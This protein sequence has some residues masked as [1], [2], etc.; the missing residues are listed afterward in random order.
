MPLEDELSLALFIRR[1][2]LRRNAANFRSAGGKVKSHSALPDRWFSPILPVG[3]LP[4]RFRLLTLLALLFAAASASRGA[5]PPEPASG[6]EDPR[7]RLERKPPA[8]EPKKFRDVQDSQ[9]NRF[10]VDEEGNVYTTG[11]PNPRRQPASAENI[12]FYYN[13]AIDMMNRGYTAQA[14]ELYREIL[15]LPPKAP[16][17]VRAQEGIRKNY[18]EVRNFNL[19]NQSLDIQDLVYVIRHV[20]DGRVVYENEKYRFRLRYPVNW[21]AEEEARNRTPEFDLRESGEDWCLFMLG[22]GERKIGCFPSA[23]EAEERERQ[24]RAEPPEGSYASMTLFPLELPGPGGEKVTVAIGFRAERLADGTAVER[25]RQRWVDRLFEV[26]RA[27]D[28]MSDLKRQSRTAGPDRLRDR[29]EMQAEER[30][31]VGDEVFIV[32]RRFGYY[33]TF[34]ATPGTYEAAREI[35]DRFLGDLEVLP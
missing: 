7:P 12:E 31:F 32:R 1:H 9:G 28:K 24:V 2:A 23:E 5:P 3:S 13:Y 18:D 33:A 10:K 29:F 27:S 8:A 21:K 14:L 34:T 35:F 17:V 25:F 20:E 4:V 16:V 6:G 19:K 15:A 11:A 26:D 22:A 30:R